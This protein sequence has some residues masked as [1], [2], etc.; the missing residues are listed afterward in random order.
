[1]CHFG[2]GAGSRRLL[3]RIPAA[4]QMMYGHLLG[5]FQERKGVREEELAPRASVAVNMEK[6]VLRS[7]G[8]LK[9]SPP[10]AAFGR[11]LPHTVYEGALATG[12]ARTL[13]QGAGGSGTGAAN[14]HFAATILD[15]F[16]RSK[17][18]C[19]GGSG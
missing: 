18:A 4:R 11:D 10:T 1:M 2:P 3:T 15:M 5:V 9:T 8:A 17:L 19:Q 7:P 14:G 16:L 13:F 12:G 6:P